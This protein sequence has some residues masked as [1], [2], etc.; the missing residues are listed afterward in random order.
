MTI[1]FP[2]GFRESLEFKRLLGVLLSDPINSTRAQC[3][4]TDIFFS[5]FQTLY[6]SMT[7]GGQPGML[8]A[9][10]QPILVSELT[11]SGENGEFVLQQLIGTAKLL[12]VNDDGLFCPMFE[13]YNKPGGGNS[14]MQSMGGKAVAFDKRVKKVTE[15]LLAEG[16]RIPGTVLQDTTGQ[17]L[18]AARTGRMQNLVVRC[19]LALC[20]QIHGG[21]DYTA[22]LVQNALGVIDAFTDEQIQA[23]IKLIVK[24]RA[25]GKFSGHAALIGMTTEKLLPRFSEMKQTLEPVDG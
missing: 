20:K 23:I 16:L 5:V 1:N 10:D 12:V 25:T 24:H 4:A 13:R 2:T 11:A 22:E 15:N 14:R 21:K 18:D 19:D 6:N 9:S 7:E 17:P 8:S 3:V